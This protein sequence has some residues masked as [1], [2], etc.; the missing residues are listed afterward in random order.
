MLVLDAGAFIAAERDS[1]EV[2]ALVKHERERR[3]AVDRRGVPCLNYQIAKAL[4]PKH[5][6][7]GCWELRK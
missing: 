2:V 4:G 3:R 6:Y 1:R 7:L 5:P